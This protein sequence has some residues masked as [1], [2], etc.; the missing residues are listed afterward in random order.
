MTG[1]LRTHVHVTDAAGRAI[2]FGPGD[3]VP[4]WAADKITNPRAW[5][6][7][8]V[9]GPSVRANPEPPPRHGAG[10]GKAAWAAYAAALGVTVEGGASRE[11]IIAAVG[12]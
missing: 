10:S 4:A 7:A 9:G 6:S 11:D 5:T 8:P 12:D 3:D 1:R 2:V